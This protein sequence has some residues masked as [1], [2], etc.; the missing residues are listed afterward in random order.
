MKL[1]IALRE[2]KK[3][4]DTHDWNNDKPYEW[5]LETLTGKTFAKNKFYFMYTDFHSSLFSF[6][7]VE[8]K[9]N[10]FLKKTKSL[11]WT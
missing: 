4:N 9:E 11:N 2:H 6:T 10:V 1:P 5:S 8:G 7:K 3:M